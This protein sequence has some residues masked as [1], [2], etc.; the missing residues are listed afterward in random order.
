MLYWHLQKNVMDQPVNC[1]E[2]PK[3]ISCL[4]PRREAR[5]GGQIAGKKWGTNEPFYSY[6]KYLQMTDT[7][8]TDL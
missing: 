1:E 3:A 6:C 5:G 8:S 2:R 4:A 7:E